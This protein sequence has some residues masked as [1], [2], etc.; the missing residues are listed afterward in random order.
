MDWL[1]GAKGTFKGVW[2]TTFYNAVNRQ[3]DA[4]LRMAEQ[5]HEAGL[6][7]LKEL[8][9]TLNDLADVDDFST[10]QN[11]LHLSKEQ[12]M[13]IY[14]ALRNQLSLDALVNG[15]KITIKTA[16]AVIGNLDQKYKD[17][18]DFII[19]EYQQH[20]GR[21]R[22][23][24][25]KL[26]NEDLGKEEFYTPIIRLEQNETVSKQEIIDQLLERHGLKKGYIE[27][28]FTINRKNIAP[29]HQKPMDLRLISI[30]QGQVQK[31]EHFIAFTDLVKGLRKL[32]SNES[33]RAMVEQKLGK[34]GKVVIDNYISRV[35]NPNI[36]RSWEG[37]AG[38]SHYL[39]RNVAMAYLSFNVMTI[40]KQMPSS[41][42][43]LKDAGPSAM[44]SAAWDFAQRPREIWNQVRDKDPQVRNAFIEREMEELRRQ[45]PYIKDQDVVGK[46]NK[47]IAVV[48]DKGMIGIRYAD[49]IA[50]SI[51]WWAVYQKN[52]QLGLSEA[53]AVVEAQNATLRT[54]P[55]ASPKDLANLY[56]NN[57]YLNWFTM[58]TNQLNNIWNITT[59]DMFAYWSNKKYQESAMTLFAVGT[60]AMVLWMLVNKKL[61]E[62]EEDLVDAALDQS[63]NMLPLINGGAMVGKRGWGSLTPPPLQTVVDIG[64]IYSAKDKEKQAIK[65]LKSS[66]VLTGI[67][68]SAIQRAYRTLETGEPAQLLGGQQSQQRIKF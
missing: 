19:D 6:Q 62:D 63:L 4:E 58:F 42:L 27:K 55:A 40:A 43:Y 8:G 33:V 26:T 61:P 21:I 67:P 65:A 57:E 10:L 28:K 47:I 5:R 16:N 18:A 44:F 12:Q 7:K 59:Y 2:H 23:V 51:G 17:M 9:L 56:A 48:G 11:G 64:G 68:V 46:I 34:Q 54:Q 29:E 20:Y 50:R 60:N 30:W 24:Y 1:D 13:G 37:L 41:V 38:V 45:L 66:L 36:Y 22:E 3:T 49:G 53:E 39:R 25:V 15:N 32:M 35:A 31:Q 14:T 52:L